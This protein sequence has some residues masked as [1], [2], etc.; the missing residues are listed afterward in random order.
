MPGLVGGPGVSSTTRGFLDA[1]DPALWPSERAPRV[2]LAQVNSRL[3]AYRDA[4]GLD[5]GLDFHSL[6][7]SYV[8]HLIETGW[9]PL[10]V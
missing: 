6:R 3:S 4:L 9:D 10:F 5:A 1:L 8:T 2:V 7:R